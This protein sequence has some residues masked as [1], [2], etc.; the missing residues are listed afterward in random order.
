MFVGCN[1]SLV[2][3]WRSILSLAPSGMGFSSPCDAAGL[4]DL[5]RT[6]DQEV[7]HSEV[8]RLLPG[9]MAAA[10]AS[11][12]KRA[13]FVKLKRYNNTWSLEKQIKIN[14]NWF[15]RNHWR[16]PLAALNPPK[17]DKGFETT[18]PSAVQKAGTREVFYQSTQILEIWGRSAWGYPRRLCKIS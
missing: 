4:A 16:T 8:G 17:E 6:V 1:P 2:G 11:P 18:L 13:C 14:K 9:E 5:P 15:Q 12:V 10:T 3:V 7:R